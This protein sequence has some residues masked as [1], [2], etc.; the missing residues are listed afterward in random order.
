MSSVNTRTS[1]LIRHAM[2]TITIPSTPPAAEIAMRGWN[3]S[4]AQERIS[5]AE[6]C[7]KRAA[8]SRICASS[9]SKMG[10]AGFLAIPQFLSSGP[11]GPRYAS[12]QTRS[13]TR[14]WNA[15]SWTEGRMSCSPQYGQ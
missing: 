7:S 1:G 5:S 10:S 13:H 15:P 12:D 2:S 9:S 3:W 8:A 14:Q 11:A 6:A 4:S